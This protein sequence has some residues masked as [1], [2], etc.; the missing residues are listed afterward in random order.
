MPK[1]CKCG[2]DI[3][4]CPT[5]KKE[6]CPKDCPAND[7]GECQR[8]VEFRSLDPRWIKARNLVRVGDFPAAA[9][10]VAQIPTRRY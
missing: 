8:C 3:Y 6:R 5:C 9:N 2:A 7:I 4:I 10:L 1:Q